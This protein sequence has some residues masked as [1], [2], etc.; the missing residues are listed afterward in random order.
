MLEIKVNMLE[1]K[2]I[3]WK[4]SQYMYVRKQVNMYEGHSISNAILTIM[5]CLNTLFNIDLVFL[6]HKFNSPSSR[7]FNT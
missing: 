5:F 6:K 4:V 3:C 1:S 2:S 7:Q